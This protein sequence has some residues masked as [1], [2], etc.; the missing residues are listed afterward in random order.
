MTNYVNYQVALVPENAEL[1]NQLNELLITG[2]ASPKVAKAAA[3]PTK[4]PAKAA[5]STSAEDADKPTGSGTTLDEFKKAAKV[6]K[7]EH[8]EEFTMQ[9]MKDAGIKV[10]TTL[11]KSMSAVHADQYDMIIALWEAGPQESEDDLGDDDGL[12]EDDDGLDE[13]VPSA[14]AV[15]KALKAYSKSESREAAKAIM[16]KYKVKALSDVPNCDDATLIAMFAELV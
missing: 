4:V 12:G 2:E 1:I 5:A 3:E 10:A 13:E 8:G 11:G 16:T 14:E 6:A 7:K 15:Q 9:V